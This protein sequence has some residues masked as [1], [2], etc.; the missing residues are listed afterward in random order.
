[1]SFSKKMISIVNITDNVYSR[2][3]LKKQPSAVNFPG[4][5]LQYDEPMKYYYLKIFVNFAASDTNE[6][7]Y[8]VINLI[9]GLNLITITKQVLCLLLKNYELDSK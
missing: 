9:P 8:S 4:D 3:E 2:S 6:N 5:S 7:I 1:M